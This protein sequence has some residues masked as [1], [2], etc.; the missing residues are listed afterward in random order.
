MESRSLSGHLGGLVSSAGEIAGQVRD[1]VHTGYDY[2]ADRYDSLKFGAKTLAAV[3]GV[4]FVSAQAAELTANVEPV[5]AQDNTPEAEAPQASESAVSFRKKC[6]REGLARPAV[7]A[8]LRHP[9]ARNQE[10]RSQISLYGLSGECADAGYEQ[11]ARVR[12]RMEEPRRGGKLVDL[13]R[14]RSL[15]LLTPP[16]GLIARNVISVKPDGRVG[17]KAYFHRTP[18]RGETEVIEE[19]TE[20]VRNPKGKKIDQ[21][22]FKT[23]VDVMAPRR[24]R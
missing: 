1:A 15:K 5:V 7:E 23:D 4:A 17:R 24:K 3:G 19:I 16:E 18:G 14:G 6:I 10:L 11:S 2:I 21:R 13:I 12:V 22:T 8:F 20:I 9:G